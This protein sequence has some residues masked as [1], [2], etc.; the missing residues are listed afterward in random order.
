MEDIH[1]RIY[2]FSF[3]TLLYTNVYILP[4]KS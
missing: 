3:Y 1:I 2:L 4:E